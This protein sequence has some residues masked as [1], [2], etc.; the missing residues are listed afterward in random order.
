MN[1]ERQLSEQHH[2]QGLERFYK[3]QEFFRDIG[4]RELRQKEIWRLALDYQLAFWHGLELRDE[5]SSSLKMLP[6]GLKPAEFHTLAVDDEAL[7][8]EV[9]GTNLRAAVVQIGADHKPHVKETLQDQNHFYISVPLEKREFESADDFFQTLISP[10]QQL[11]SNFHPKAVAIIYSFP[12]DAEISDQI[13][14][15]KSRK[16]TKDFA[17]SGIEG[18]A[19]GAEIMKKMEKNGRITQD[20]PYV[21]L[22]DTPAVLLS[23]EGAG[24]GGVLASGF[25]FAALVN[26]QI[27]NTESGGFDGVPES[28]LSIAVDY[29]SSNRGEQ[30]AEKQISGMYLEEQMKLIILGLTRAGC[31]EAEVADN[32]TS[33]FISDL[34]RMDERGVESLD[35]DILGNIDTYDLAILQSVAARLRKRS[36]Q[37]V[38][39]MAGTIAGMLASEAEGD[40][41]I[42]E[43]EVPVEGPVFWD[44]PLYRQTAERCA[45]MISRKRVRFIERPYAGI[46]GAGVAALSLLQRV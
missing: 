34:L 12:A 23:H 5:S 19:V 3:A 13:I 37:I 45:N 9:G 40:D 14:D 39:A 35:N 31:L 25:N 27:F 2:L 33:K 10:C 8:I 41:K 38:G 36:A 18:V 17:V 32:I 11:P 15:V 43:F 30:L 44:I 21:V 16:M 24:I 1:I 26:G 28:E 42:E 7:V 4:L 46:L 6:T 20:L 22:N 29:H